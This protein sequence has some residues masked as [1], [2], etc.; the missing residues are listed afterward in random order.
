[1]SFVS[2]FNKKENLNDENYEKDKYKKEKYDTVTQDLKEKDYKYDKKNNFDK[3]LDEIED[4]YNKRDYRDRDRDYDRDDDRD[5]DRDYKNDN[6]YNKDDRDY[7]YHR[8]N[9]RDDDRNYRD[10][11]IDSEKYDP[12]KDQSIKNIDNFLYKK[13]IQILKIFKMKNR[14]ILL[15]VLLKE[16]GKCVLIYVDP[17][18]YEIECQYNNSIVGRD[19]V[20]DIELFRINHKHIY[21]VCDCYPELM[22]QTQE[23]RVNIENEKNKVY[24]TH[25]EQICIQLNNFKKIVK[26]TK[27][28]LGII[29]EYSIS[30]INDEN[31]IELFTITDTSP[32]K[33][34]KMKIYLVYDLNT[35]MNNIDNIEFEIERLVPSFIDELNKDNKELRKHMESNSVLN[36]INSVKN[37]LDKLETKKKSLIQDSDNLKEI[38]KTS[39]KNLS[40]AKN[41]KDNV[42]QRFTVEKLDNTKQEIMYFM[43]DVDDEYNNILSHT[44]N[45]MNLID[46]QCRNI[47]EYIEFIKKYCDFN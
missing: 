30:F 31:D 20:H 19:N 7:R 23:H 28:K 33:F 36:N 22:K 9:D 15:L 21:E 3:E 42:Q 41:K 38:F 1:M 45:M 16:L 43:I 8:E 17:S 6:K 14:C 18:K 29:T 47:N 40:K 44:L 39:K 11:R 4:K 5:D 2:F 27:S 32:D 26:S 10:R 35:F 25:F 13:N 12:Y 24:L 46:K 34:S 37:L